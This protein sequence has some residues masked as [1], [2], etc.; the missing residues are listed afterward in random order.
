MF[1]EFLAVGGVASEYALGVLD[2]NIAR[3][4]INGRAGSGVAQVDGVAQKIGVKMFPQELSVLGVKTG[5]A[6]VQVRPF[7]QITH[8]IQ[9]AVGDDG[10]GHA[11]KVRRP[12]G[13]AGVK[14]GGK[15]LLRRRAVL[16]RSAPIQ[17][18]VGGRQ[19]A[20]ANQGQTGQAGDKPD[21]S[22]HRQLPGRTG[23]DSRAR[24]RRPSWSSCSL[25]NIP[26]R[27][28]TCK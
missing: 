3:F 23:C 11:G 1:P 27:R 5:H 26:Q 19:G 6:L 20:G 8:D 2:V 18:A 13:V 21:S 10:R 22:I 15:I 16:I 9:P 28:L 14:D 4:G 12:Q 7:A 25:A 24:P 17:P